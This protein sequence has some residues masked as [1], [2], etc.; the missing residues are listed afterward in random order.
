[1]MMNDTARTWITVRHVAVVLPPKTEPAF[2]VWI[3]GSENGSLVYGTFEAARLDY[4][5]LITAL[6]DLEG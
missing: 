2:Q 5:R 6:I 3:Q 4:E 1:M